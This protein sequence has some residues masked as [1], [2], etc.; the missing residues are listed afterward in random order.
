M[1][2]D[3]RKIRKRTVTGFQLIHIDEFI[4][5]LMREEVVCDINVPTLPKRRELIMRTCMHV[6]IL[7]VRKCY[8][9]SVP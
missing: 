7:L 8:S 2:N 9:K 6:H 1:Y 5:E 3:Y 4:D